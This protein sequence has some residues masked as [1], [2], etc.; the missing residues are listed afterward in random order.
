MRPAGS[1][2]GR[3]ERLSLGARVVRAPF[4]CDHEE[5]E[6]FD[7]NQPSK[8]MKDYIGKRVQRDP[9]Q[10][11]VLHPHTIDEVVGVV[12]DVYL[13]ADCGPMFLILADGTGR[14]ETFCATGFKVVE[15]D[16]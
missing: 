4:N 12:Q 10:A 2:G 3:A 9:F 11:G 14:L 5:Y 16:G 7:R 15:Q 8:L 1:L 13:N 6:M